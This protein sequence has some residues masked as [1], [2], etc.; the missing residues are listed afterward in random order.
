MEKTASKQWFLFFDQTFDQL[1]HY[2]SRRVKTKRIAQFLIESVYTRFYEDLASGKG[3]LALPYLY[4][5]GWQLLSAE[6]E[7]TYGQQKTHEKTENMKYFDDVYRFNRGTEASS[8]AASD[9]G[10]HTSSDKTFSWDER[11]RLF[12]QLLPLEREVLFLTAFEGLA[13]ADRAYVLNLSESDGTKFFYTTLKKVKELLDKDVHS[14]IPA[15]YF[16]DILGLL[17][18]VRVRE[19]IDVDQ[20]FAATLR[21][22]L[23]KK[24]AIIVPS[25][26]IAPD[27]LEVEE[28]QRPVVADED[29]LPSFVG[30]DFFALF[31]RKFQGVLLAGLT[32]LVSLGLYGGLASESARVR[33][34][35]KNESIVFSDAF[36]ADER[37]SFSREV[38]LK[39]LRDRDFDTVVVE[40]MDD[41]RRS[42]T[43]DF[44][45]GSEEKFVLVPFAGNPPWRTNRYQRIALR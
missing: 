14:P 15:S 13:D 38:L 5:V 11:L 27:D 21:S 8:S 7:K 20:S 12:Q 29:P 30:E 37:A 23:M 32:I 1:Y 44:A 3:Y 39:L 9:G 24:Y 22:R 36:S 42:V 2:V 40:K 16:G 18:D 4:R 43:F 31:W 6:L 25:E 45:D 10:V 33:G 17:R 19:S 34:I 35:L 26:N 41:S 28:P